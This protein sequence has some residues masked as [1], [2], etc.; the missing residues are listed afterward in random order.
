MTRRFLALF[1]LLAVVGL[2][3][4]TGDAHAAT[5]P[6]TTPVD[7]PIGNTLIGVYASVG[8][9]LFSRA[10]VGG[11]VLP[12]VVAGAIATCGYM[13]FDTLFVER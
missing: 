3:L 6:V 13:F 5:A 8:C 2:W 9:G 10:L 11:M 1:A 7:P 4:A 12:G